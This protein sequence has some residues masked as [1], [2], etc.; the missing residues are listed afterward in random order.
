MPEATT[1]GSQ[2][3]WGRIARRIR[4]P[5]GFLFAV[6]YFWRARPDWRSL[7]LGGAVAAAGVFLRAMASG[8][9]KK[10][11]QLATTG[12]YAYCRNPLYLGSIIIATGFAIAARDLWVAIGIVGLF[13][14]IYVP[15][16][17]SEE[18]FLRQQ[19]AEYENYARRVPRLL[20]KTVWFQGLTS[21][22][23][24]ELYLQHREYNAL[25]GAAA[26]LAALVVKMLWFSGS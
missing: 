25:I 14:L 6:F 12:P 18:T 10:N 8:Q 3:S 24:R 23:S 21:G 9:V 15:V 17:R 20:P 22:F 1:V 19:F 16:I 2:L 7:V 26:M 13:S 11:E 5:L 4:V